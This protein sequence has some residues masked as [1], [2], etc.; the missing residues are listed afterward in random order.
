MLEAAAPTKGS[1][2]KLFLDL[3]RHGGYAVCNQ[4]IAFYHWGEFGNEYE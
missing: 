1:F 2:P 4:V 3:V